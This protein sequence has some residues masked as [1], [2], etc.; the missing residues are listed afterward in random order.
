MLLAFVEA[1]AQ[2][3]PLFIAQALAHFAL[4][5]PALLAH[6]LALFGPRQASAFAHSL[7][8]VTPL[9]DRFLPSLF[10]PKDLGA[11]DDLYD[12]LPGPRRLSSIR[13]RRR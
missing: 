6:A 1:Q 11:I 3:R 10:Q 9:V 5:L 7:A 4:P 2:P 12:F 8:Q 13:D